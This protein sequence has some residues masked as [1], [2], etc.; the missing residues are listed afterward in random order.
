MLAGLAATTVAGAGACGSNGG[1]GGSGGAAGT[2][3]AAGGGGASG[4]VLYPQQAEGPFYLD[5]DSLRRDIS[6]DRVGMALKL[7]VQVQSAECSPLR[8][9]VVDVWHCDADG[10]YSGFAGQLGGLDTTGE[11]FLRGTQVT[12]ADGVAEF[13]TVYPGWY[14]GR[15]TH[16]HF[17]VHTS[18]TMEA[19]SQLY[20]PEDVTSEIY[21]TAPYDARGPKDTPNSADG[22]ATANPAPLAVVT[23]DVSSGFTATI[24]VTVA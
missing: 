20:F 22:I 17:K 7:V 23:G 19:T 13:A 8:D 16:V 2:G 15:T 14:P 1:A 5:L 4:C 12:G 3:G 24:R 11:T 21:G 10:V 6:E 9:L 18:S